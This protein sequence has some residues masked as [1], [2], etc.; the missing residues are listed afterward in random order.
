MNESMDLPRL[1]LN[2]TQEDND[3]CEKLGNGLR[4]LDA[5][6]KAQRRA[7]NV[8]GANHTGTQIVKL[9][10]RIYNILWN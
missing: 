4:A 10:R 8:A 2:A 6:R 7:F 9:R 5:L 1:S 3:R